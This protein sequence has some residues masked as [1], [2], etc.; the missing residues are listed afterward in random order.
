MFEIRLNL[1][2]SS[3]N[4][5]SAGPTDD[6]CTER[7]KIIIMVIDPEHRYFYEATKTN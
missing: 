6:P 5:F 7:I 3:P 1:A 4:P 2:S